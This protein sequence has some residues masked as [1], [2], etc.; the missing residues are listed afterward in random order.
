MFKKTISCLLLSTLIL[1]INCMNTD[2]QTELFNA[3]SRAD[4]KTTQNLISAG[5]DINSLQTTDIVDDEVGLPIKLAPIHVAVLKKHY[6]IVKLLIDNKADVNITNEVE[7]TPLDLAIKVGDL[8]IVKLLINNKANVNAQNKAKCG[9]API[10]YTILHM[11]VNIASLL[12]ASGASVNI[13]LCGMSILS[14]AIQNNKPDITRLFIKNN[15]NV[16]IQNPEDKSTLLHLAVKRGCSL[17]IVKALLKAGIDKNIKDI[18][19]NTATD[20]TVDQ[21]VTDAPDIA[22]Q[23]K[24]KDYITKFNYDTYLKTRPLVILVIDFIKNNKN[25]FSENL[26]YIL[27]EELFEKLK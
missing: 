15:A 13:D 6:D 14:Y 3:V 26:S 12:I 18:N 24:I 16:N 2:L 7:D 20:L 17:K 23:Q 11:H 19:D 9:R 27:P 21:D 4:L 8:E 5:I 10:F 22:T 25:K 1:S